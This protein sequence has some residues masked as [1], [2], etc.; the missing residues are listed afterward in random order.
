MIAVDERGSQC[1]WVSFRG[2]TPVLIEA[3]IAPGID[4]ITFVINSTRPDAIV[5]K[6]SM[7]S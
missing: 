1:N 5:L 2:P 7:L 4:W 3:R 6:K